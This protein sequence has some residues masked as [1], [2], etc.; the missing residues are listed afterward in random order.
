MTTICRPSPAHQTTTNGSTT[1][2]VTQGPI[3]AAYH[4]FTRSTTKETFTIELALRAQ[5]VAT[6][7]SRDLVDYP[8]DHGEPP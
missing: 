7:V 5:S 8:M 1:Y 4:S 3:V 2:T 6:S